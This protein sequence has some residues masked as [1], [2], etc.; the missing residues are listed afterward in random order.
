MNDPFKELLIITDRLHAPDGCPWDREQTFESL[1]PYVLEEAHEVLEAVEEGD[2]SKIIEE[3]GDLFYNVIF[4]AKV[5]DKAGRFSIQDIL[6]NLCK[7][8][9]RRHPHVF[10]KETAATIEEVYHHWERAK[11][12]EGGKISVLDGVPKTLPSLS[13][14]QKVVKRMQKHQYP[15]EFER[16]IPEKGKE[17]LAQTL[18]NL[19]CEANKEGIDLEDTFRSLLQK[20]EREFRAWEKALPTSS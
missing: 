13:R 20:E 8:L 7:K 14:A 6:E 19:V 16:P 10:G 12:K 17:R 15:V 5:A 11:K 18:L 1:K 3:L 2:D 9:V 4:Y